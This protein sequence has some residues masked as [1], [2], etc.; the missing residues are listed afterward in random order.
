MNHIWQ[1]DPFL[2][3]AYRVSEA[4]DTYPE[5]NVIKSIK[6]IRFIHN[7]YLIDATLMSLLHQM[8][9][10]KEA[11]IAAQSFVEQ[12]QRGTFIKGLYLYGK[13]RTGKTFLLSAI[14]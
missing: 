5:K 3:I 2:H 12:F 6:L 10:E 4:Y 13:Y 11:L 1:P 9:K 14:A 7:D 8:M